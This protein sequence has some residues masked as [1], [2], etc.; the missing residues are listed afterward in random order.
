M[1]LCCSL[2]CAANVSSIIC[3]H[4]KARPPVVVPVPQGFTTA[5]RGAGTNQQRIVV[6][7]RASVTD[8]EPLHDSFAHGDYT[9]RKR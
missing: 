3:S 6:V 7:S 1:K 8:P 9:S 2:L 4:S 5:H